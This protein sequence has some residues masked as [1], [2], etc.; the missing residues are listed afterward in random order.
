M[1]GWG[2]YFII[3][4]PTSTP[5]RASLPRFYPLGS[6]IGQNPAREEHVIAPI[7]QMS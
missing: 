5:T 2:S 7:L 4:A 6:L 1:G 3:W